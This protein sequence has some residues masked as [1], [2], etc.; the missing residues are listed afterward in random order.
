MRAGG[1]MRVRGLVVA[2]SLA[3]TGAGWA[4]DTVQE[5]LAESAT[6]FSEIMKTPDKGIPQDL[7]EKAD[8]VII[9]P[10]VKKAAFVVGG[11]YGKGFA[12]CR[13]QNGPGWGAPAAMQ[14]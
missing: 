5:R 3:V 12:T 14:L 10:N 4:A 7:L 9:L 1:I 8:C 13:N 6:V 11:E 2:A